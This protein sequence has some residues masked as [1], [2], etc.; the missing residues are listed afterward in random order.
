MGFFRANMNKQ[1]N[2]HFQLNSECKAVKNA[3]WKGEAN[4]LAIYHFM[5]CS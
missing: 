4:Q 2:E 1:W 5:K 3:N